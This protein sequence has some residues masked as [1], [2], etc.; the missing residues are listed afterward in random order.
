MS[1][2]HTISESETPFRYI[3]PVAARPSTPNS[4]E[5]PFPI[6]YSVAKTLGLTC[7][8][9]PHSSSQQQQQQQPRSLS[10]ASSLS[11]S[12]IS[13][14]RPVE[15][16][17]LLSSDD[18][19][20]DEVPFTPKRH[21]PTAAFDFR[22]QPPVLLQPA[23]TQSA[24]PQ[25]Q[26]SAPVRSTY[27]P[28][29]SSSSARFC[30]V[31]VPIKRP[32]A[33]FPKTPA[34]IA[35]RELF[36]KNLHELKGPKV[37]VVN[38]IDE[39]SPSTDFR[40]VQESI[41]QAGVE[42][43]S[44]DFMVGCTCYKDNGRQMGCEYL[45]CKCLD[46]S[47][48]NHEGRRVFPYGAGKKDFRC[49]RNFYLE[50]RNHIYE[51]NKMC[52]CESNCK[53]RNVQHG[54]KVELEIFKTQNR[55]WGLRCPV[56]L[57]KGEFID[58]YRG[59]IISVAES[60]RRGAKRSPDE[61]NY[62]F[63]F[64]KFC[65]AEMITKSEFVENFPDV[66]EEYQQKINLG[67]ASTEFRDGEEWWENPEYVEYE[68]VCDGMYVGS[69][70]RFMNHSCDPNCRLFTVSY[71]HADT[72]LYELAFFTLEEIPAGMELTFDYKDEDDRTVITDEQARQV[73]ETKGYMPQ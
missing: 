31:E 45:Y 10:N 13:S 37:T 63:N 22:F 4:L 61:A 73:Q 19:S 41:L 34:T 33:V 32:Y 30:A 2:R 11:H 6:R 68:Y 65:E 3:Q 64:D 72:N 70:T 44:E 18:E 15:V 26:P 35:K 29:S 25:L 42:H 5:I 67:E 66:V 56:T 55:G 14:K 49:L 7:A 46:D 17:D 20:G 59:E 23:I 36:E 21:C 8:Y 16:V 52:N 53:N 62:F 43:V 60:D 48:L 57:R 71:N 1:E 12:S 9:P 40:F 27:V 39:S 51:C 47:Q 24:Q 28:S 38:E 54:R 50:S 69:P 58:T